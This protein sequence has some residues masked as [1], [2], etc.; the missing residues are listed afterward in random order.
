MDYRHSLFS[1]K[2]KSLTKRKVCGRINLMDKNILLNY[3]TSRKCGGCKEYIFIEDELFND[4]ASIYHFQNKTWHKPCFNEFLSGRKRKVDNIDSFLLSIVDESNNVLYNL[5]VKN[6]L[7]KYLMS[8][9]EVILLP[10]YI[11]TKMEQVFTGKFK[12]MSQPIP[13][14]DLLDMWKNP[15]QV[16]Y[17][18]K[19][20]RWKQ[21]EGVS[22]INYSLAIL[23]GSYAKYLDWKQSKTIENIK[24]EKDIVQFRQ[25]DMNKIGTGNQADEDI[26]AEEGD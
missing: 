22:A 17:L 15:K 6:H 18:D 10:N 8:K 24:T 16:A 2:P 13:P 11:Y 1:N 12:N 26:F 3:K 21:L 14:Q 9:Y 25:I 4:T 23:T 5:C 20:C 7:Y 19:M